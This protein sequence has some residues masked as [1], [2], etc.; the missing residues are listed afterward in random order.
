MATINAVD[1]LISWNFKHIVNVTRIRGYKA[2]NM[3]LGILQLT[4]VHQKKLYTM[5]TKAIIKKDF[6]AV[7]FMRTTRD[8]ISA[9]TQNMNFA[10]LKKYFEQRRLKLK[11]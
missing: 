4:F 2:V 1:F 5:E 7:K 9:E 8:K 6:D 11:K 3:K 10:G